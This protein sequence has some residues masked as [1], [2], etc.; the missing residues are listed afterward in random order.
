MKGNHENKDGNSVEKTTTSNP[1]S[2]V[3]RTLGDFL[4]SLFGEWKGVARVCVI[5]TVIFILFFGMGPWM[6]PKNLS[7]YNVRIGMN[8]ELAFVQVPQVFGER[9]KTHFYLISASRLWT[10]TEIDVK[11]GDILTV[12]S[13]SGG[14]NLAAHRLWEAA[15]LDYRPPQPWEY[16]SRERPKAYPRNQETERNEFV[17]HPGANYGAL[18]LYICPFSSDSCPSL[19]NSATLRPPLNRIEI[20]DDRGISKY[21]V[22]QDGRLYFTVN[23][24][25]VDKRDIY[26]ASD[27]AY[28]KRQIQLDSIAKWDPLFRA[29]LNRKWGFRPKDLQ[30]WQAMKSRDSLLWERVV[31]TYP[32]IWY[33]DNVGFYAVFINVQSPD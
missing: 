14:V 7:Q 8:N 17:L 15:D 26:V 2:N 33:D 21:P 22:K 28:Q 30:L 4:S 18:L 20:I 32:E 24:I 13:I 11:S 6:L 23:D 19:E 10:D 9:E 29:S 31:K 16:L 12:N 25:V 3:G 27:E 1:S 5:L